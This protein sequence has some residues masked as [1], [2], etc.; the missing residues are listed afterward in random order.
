MQAGPL[1]CHINVVE[2]VVVY[3]KPY[4]KAWQ[5]MARHGKA[6]QGMARHGR[7]WQGMARHGVM[8][9]AEV[10]AQAVIKDESRVREKMKQR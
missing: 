7:A 4:G 10:G 3:A 8:K 5:G 1:R 2:A 6:W 9:T